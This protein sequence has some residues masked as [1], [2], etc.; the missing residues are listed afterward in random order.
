MTKTTQLISDAD[1]T[2]PAARPSSRSSLD[3]GKMEL[4]HVLAYDIGGSHATAGIVDCSSLSVSCVR[5]H[6]LDSDG[7][8]ESILAA[9]LALGEEA[10][11]ES[12]RLG[13]HPSA[14]ALAVPGPFDY[15]HGISLL[16]HKYSSLYEM[17]LQRE[18]GIRFCMNDRMIVFLNDA[19]AFLLGEN[20]AGAA[21]G[22]TRSVGLTLGTGIGSAFSIGGEIVENRHSVPP[23]GEIYCLPWGDGTVEDAISTRAIQE[24]YR[25]LTGKTKTVKGICSVASDDSDAMSV[26]REFGSNLG[27]VIRDFCM[28]FCPEAVVLGGEISRSAH[29]FLAD[30]SS[31]AG[32]ADG[33]LLR[34]CKLF[35]DAPL[36]GSAV[37][38]M[39]TL[40]V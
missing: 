34:V 30:A 1:N 28:A 19:Q 17:N 31:S 18:L 25:Q 35:K 27:L 4:T 13:T 37:R 3:N 16:R 22:V 9:L 26:M 29:L 24:R 38:C 7:P 11:A 20:H 32:E 15:E 40:C 21:K 33:D 10:I 6:A 23:G 2:S 39:K 12:G 5:S 14:I 36:V 8:A